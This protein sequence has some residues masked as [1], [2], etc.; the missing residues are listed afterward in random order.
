MGILDQIT[1][2]QNQG[3]PNE[4]I[5]RNLQEQ[6]ISPKE[7]ND[8]LSQAQIKSAVSSEQYG[9]PSPEGMYSPSTQEANPPNVDVSQ[10][11]SSPLAPLFDMQE[12]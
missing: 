6:G 9:V 10:E 12:N 5:V 7:I 2:M 4:D 8:A 11:Y 1:Q 3:I